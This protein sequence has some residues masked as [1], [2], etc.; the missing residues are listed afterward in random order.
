MKNLRTVAT[1]E[2]GSGPNS[3]IDMKMKNWPLAPAAD[4]VIIFHKTS[5]CR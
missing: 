1:I 4:R 5:G 2:V 3:L